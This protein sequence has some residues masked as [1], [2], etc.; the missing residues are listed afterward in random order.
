MKKDNDQYE[1]DCGQYGDAVPLDDT[2]IQFNQ[3]AAN[4]SNDR[5]VN[6]GGFNSRIFLT[7]QESEYAQMLWNINDILPAGTMLLFGKPKKGKSYLALMMSI[8]I[9]GGHEVFGKP[10]SGRTVLYLGL[11]DSMRRMKN[12]VLSCS[13]AL[14]IDTHTFNTNFHTCIESR[15]I[16]NGLTDDIHLWMKEHPETGLI[17]FDMLK[18][19]VGRPKGIDLYT[20]QARVGDTLTKLCHDYP[21]LSIMVIHHSRKLDSTDPFDV[22]SG[23][24]GMSGSYDSLGTI[25]DTDGSRMLHITGRDLESVTIPLLMSDRGMYTLEAVA[26]GYIEQQGMSSTRRKV[27]DAV[28]STQP[29]TRKDIVSG[30]GLD[31]SAVDQQL[32][33]LVRAGLIEHTERGHY[34]KTGKRFQEEVY[35]PYKNYKNYKNGA[36]DGREFYTSY[37]RMERL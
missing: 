24:T 3:T 33:L 4:T 25:M 16:D 2:V 27:F 28:A 36:S 17:V 12:R 30:C 37:M 34:Q 26:P 18:N 8:C 14:D 13:A 23:T 20:E 10:S 22:V 32:R 1:P 5:G 35:L 19:I 21:S 7:T 11:E 15:T 29:M 31:G 6:T 9:A